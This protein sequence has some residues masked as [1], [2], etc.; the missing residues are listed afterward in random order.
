MLNR[1]SNK[2]LLATFVEPCA[3]TSLPAE[4]QPKINKIYQW[5]FLKVVV[6]KCSPKGA[7]NS[8]FRRKPCT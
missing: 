5:H 1:K 2:K 7:M 4:S 6:L 8:F 3:P